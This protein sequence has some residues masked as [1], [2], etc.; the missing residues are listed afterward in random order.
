MALRQTI[1]AMGLLIIALGPEPAAAAAIF[2]CTE[3]GGSV[4]Y[5]ES[6]C[7]DSSAGRTLDVPAEYPAID[8]RQRDSLLTREAALDQ[9]LEARR[10]RE[11]RETIASIG[12]DAQVQAAQGQDQAGAPAYVVAWPRV[13]GSRPMH[14]AHRTHRD[15]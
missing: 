7:P 2:R 14:R 12:R 3:P 1:L 10:E 5:Q 9:R 6:P 8:P 13:T 4:T 15:T 11:S